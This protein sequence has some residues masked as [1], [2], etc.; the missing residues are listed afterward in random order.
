MTSRIEEGRHA[1]TREPEGEQAY[2]PEGLEEPEGQQPES[3]A[4][5]HQA[6]TD[7]LHIPEAHSSEAG[8]SSRLREARLAV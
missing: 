7:G 3:D 6:L 4:R 1:A 2:V 5:W 8:W